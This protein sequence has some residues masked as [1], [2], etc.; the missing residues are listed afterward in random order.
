[1]AK[2]KIIFVSQ[3]IAPYLSVSD[4]SK[5]GRSIPQSMKSLKYEVRTF[6][7]DFGDINERRNQLHEV[8]RLSGMNIPIS[9]NDHPLVVKVASMQPSRIQVYFIDNDDYFIK[10]DTDSDSFGSNRADNDERIIFFA[11]GMVET[12][13]KLQWVPE[14]IHVSGWMTALVP[15]YVRRLFADTPG[16]PQTK[17]VYSV[18]PESEVAELPVEFFE[19]LAAEGVAEEDLA[20]WRDMTRDRKMLEKMAISY[21]DAVVFHTETP[22]PELVEWCETQGK[23]WQAAKGEGDDA[24]QYDLLYQSLIHD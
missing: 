5:W 4:N 21:A 2:Q 10:A 12:A 16:F 1:M 11:R 15:M 14:I 18:L 19:K 13:R 3:E 7:P 24:A 6:M 23:P 8:I 22:D 9:D 17:I 20:P